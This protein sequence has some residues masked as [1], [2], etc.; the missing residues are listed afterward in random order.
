MPNIDKT[1]YFPFELNDNRESKWSDVRLSFDNWEWFSKTYNTDSI[2]DYY[3]NGYGVQG[4]VL[5]SRVAAG[6]EAYPDGLEPNSEGDTCYLIFDDYESAI[7]TAKLARN[8]IS[9]K[10]SIET[11]I[12]VARENDLED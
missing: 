1:T 8:M 3:I 5:A 9:S 12:E 6:L 7:E 11:M 4:L 10:E 2:N